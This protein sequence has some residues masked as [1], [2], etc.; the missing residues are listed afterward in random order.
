MSRWSI[1]AI[2]MTGRRQGV[3]SRG[4]ARPTRAGPT[5]RAARP[6]GAPI[7][8]ILDNLSAHKG[9]TIRHWARKNCVELCFTPTYESWANPIE[10]QF[11]LSR[12]FAVANSNH[13]NHTAQTRALHAYLR[14]H[15]T[16]ARHPD[17]L[18]AQ[19]CERARVSSEKSIRWGGRPVGEAP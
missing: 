12:Q 1:P 16:N 7:Y 5:L 6:D 14:W 3:T 19:R 17:I 18:T 11:G 9:E 10:S 8:V 15:N 2:S 13:R 4:S